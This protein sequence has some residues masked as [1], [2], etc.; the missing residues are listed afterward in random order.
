MG[1]CDCSYPSAL[2]LFNLSR[3]LAAAHAGTGT[4]EKTPSC[5]SSLLR[6]ILLQSLVAI[7]AF[8]AA[9]RAEAY[10]DQPAHVVVS[11][12]AGGVA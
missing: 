10:L 5:M 8:V 9:A 2:R 4:T 6:D 1:R 11:Y 7:P 3:A 12:F